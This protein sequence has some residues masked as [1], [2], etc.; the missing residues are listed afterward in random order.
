MSNAAAVKDVTVENAYFKG[1]SVGGLIN[2]IEH[3]ANSTNN[4]C[5]IQTVTLENISYDMFQ[6]ETEGSGFAGV[7]R[8]I[9]SSIVSISDVHLTNLSI[10]KDDNASNYVASSYELDGGGIV[11]SV[12]S[13]SEAE[14]S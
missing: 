7:I 4:S 11:G 10:G 12:H 9:K 2:F 13:G 14:I 1:A 3:P 5:S 6:S 8:E